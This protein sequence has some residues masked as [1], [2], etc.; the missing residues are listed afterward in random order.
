MNPLNSP[1]EV[2]VR[3]LVL[4]AQAFPNRLDVAQLVYLDHVMVH[5]AE[6]GGRPANLHPSLPVGPG[7][8]A[9]RRRLVEQG[10]VVLMR[11]S[12]ADMTV[13]TEGFS[14]GATPEA[15]S[16]LDILEAPYLSLLQ[17]RAEW[18]TAGWI[19]DAAA[20]RGSI[21]QVT[22]NWTRQVTVRKEDR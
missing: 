3:T 6:F 15:S 17:E 13:T 14:Y 18:L 1:L 22:R 21:N 11:A 4:L 10:L 19:P 2:G 8:L 5:S 12:L 16:F 9:M 20:V 7:E